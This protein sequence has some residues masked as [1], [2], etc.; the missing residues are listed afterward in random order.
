MTSTSLLKDK[1]TLITGAS[2]GIGAAMAFRFAQEGAKLILTAR[3][4]GVLEAVAQR[5]EKETSATPMIH[6]GDVR[7]AAD[8]QSLYQTIFKTHGRLD[9]LCAN[10][11]ILKDNLIGMIDDSALQETL[12]INVRGAFNHIQPAARLMRRNKSGAIVVTSSI[13]GRVGNAGQ[14][15]YGASKAALIG[16]TLS[17]AKEL[18][19]DGIRINALAPGFIDTSMTKHLSAEIHAE[20]I[21]NIALGRIGSPEDVADAAL[22][23]ASDLSRYVTGQILGVDGGMV[24]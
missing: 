7:D 17:A 19:R 6:C 3:N 24:I 5:I 21:K 1:V 2:R 4:K 23:L 8:V 10:A 20:R 14:A 16:L 12:D 13:I 22:F 11:G 9:V 15:A 18:G